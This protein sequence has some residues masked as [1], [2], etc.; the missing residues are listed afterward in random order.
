MVR[1]YGGTSGRSGQDRLRLVVQKLCDSNG[2]TGLGSLSTQAISK[3]VVR[4]GYLQ[5]KL[6][7]AGTIN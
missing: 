3:K 4:G 6:Q 2:K 1:V 5:K 7:A